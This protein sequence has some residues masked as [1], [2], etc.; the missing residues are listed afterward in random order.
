[1]QNMLPITY[2]PLKRQIGL[3]SLKKTKETFLKNEHYCQYVIECEFGFGHTIGVA[4][5]R[6]ILSAV[7][8]V[9][10]VAIQVNNAQHLFASVSGIKSSVLDISLQLQKIAFKFNNPEEEFCF[11]SLNKTATNGG[12][13]VYASDFDENSKVKIINEDLQICKLDANGNI[14]LKVLLGKGVGYAPFA[15]HDIKN[16]PDGWFA[17]DSYFNSSSKVGYSVE[18]KTSGKKYDE[19][20]M[21]V[22]TDGSITPDQALGIAGN[23]LFKVFEPLCVPD[24]KE[25]TLLKE[26]GEIEDP[27]LCMKITDCQELSPRAIRCLVQNNILTV[28]DLVERTEVELKSLGGFGDKSFDEIITFL[29]LY[30]LQL[31]KKLN[32]RRKI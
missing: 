16:L 5:R 4:L 32:K 13:S 28:T 14:E 20:I 1:M 29:G 26:E 11:L 6:T 17:V 24:I 2:T 21:E 25:Q 8:G 22:S 7:E 30:G 27:I 12:E 19:I 18:T 23:K 31:G 9:A 3:I 10:V 15:E